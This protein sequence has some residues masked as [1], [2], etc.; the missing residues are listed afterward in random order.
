MGARA[1][2]R[3]RVAPVLLTLAVL[4]VA[5]LLGAPA[6]TAAG[7]DVTPFVNCYW[8][9]GNATYTVSVGV[10]N[11]AKTTVT[12]PIG[13]DN[14]V[15]PG[16]QDRGQPTTFA[17]GTTNNAWVVTVSAAEVAADI[18]WYLTGHTVSV[19]TVQ[20]CASRPVPQQGNALAVVAFGALSALVGAIFLGE[21][22]RRARVVA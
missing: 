19:K 21:R 20:Q 9:N 4:V 1:T 5:G 22:R 11:Q 7:P 14:K 13:V 10:D 3:G 12:V 15:S 6:A 2:W 8:D 16:A 18:N 17:A